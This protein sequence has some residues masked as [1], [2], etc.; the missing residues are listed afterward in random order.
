MRAV[1]YSLHDGQTLCR[2]L[3]PTSSELHLEALLL[4]RIMS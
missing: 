4:D 3:K 2:D 1:G